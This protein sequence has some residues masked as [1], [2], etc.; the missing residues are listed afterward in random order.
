MASLSRTCWNSKSRKHPDVPCIR[1]VQ[2]GDY[3]SFHNKNPRPF[4]KAIDL[5][6]LSRRN[7]SRL[8]RFIVLCKF[9]TGLLQS[10][11]QGYA[12]AYPALANNN[13]ELASMDEVSTIPMPFRFSF[14]ESN[15]IWLF[16][17]RSLL[18]ERKRVEEHPFNNPYTSLPI[19]SSNLIK[20][21]THIE[22]LLQRRYS[23]DTGTKTDLVQPYQ[24]KIV[25]LCFLID[26]HGYLTNVAWFQLPTIAQVHKFI[27][28][29]D[30]LW[31]TRLALTNTTK[32]LIYPEWDVE[33]HNLCPL[34]RSN[35]L[36]S[37]LNQLFTHLLVFVKA[38]ALK[39]NRALAAVYI[40][41]ALTHVSA[42]AKKAFPWLYAM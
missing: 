32:L 13:T 31:T 10:K 2:N 34:I 36:T 22:W 17:V 25:E 7:K 5:S 16:D 38:A 41:T 1:S 26:S 28:T 35:N 37:A 20:L 11:R 9:K 19:S 15:N 24:Q 27:D 18:Q 42:G 8:E 3:C 33:T 40:L 29:L 21:E 14:V 23:L 30:T 4:I 12:S 39:E 6:V